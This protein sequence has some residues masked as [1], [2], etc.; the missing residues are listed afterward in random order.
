MPNPNLNLPLDLE[1]CRILLTHLGPLV[2]H[3]APPPATQDPRPAHD[4]D[5]PSQ[6]PLDGIPN[7]TIVTV[8]VAA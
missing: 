1:G 7:R 8:S 6:R 3:D 5:N 2:D 4:N